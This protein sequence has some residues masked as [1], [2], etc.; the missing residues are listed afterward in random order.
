MILTAID[1]IVFN[2][3]RI[4]KEFILMSTII[5]IIFSK[6]FLIFLVI[7]FSLITLCYSMG[8]FDCFDEQPLNNKIIVVQHT[9]SH[10]YSNRKAIT[11]GQA[12]LVLFCHLNDIPFPEGY[13]PR[14]VDYIKVQPSHSG[15]H[16]GIIKNM[17]E[18]KGEDYLLVSSLWDYFYRID[19]IT[20]QVVFQGKTLYT[21][22]EC[23]DAFRS[24]IVPINNWKLEKDETSINYDFLVLRACIQTGYSIEQQKYH[25]RYGSL[26]LSKEMEK[27]SL[28]ITQEH[29][30][31]KTYQ[32]KMN[33]IKNN[34]NH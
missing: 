12:R 8:L 13:C 16:R 19:L 5:M 17:S 22:E 11:G 33:Q 9:V 26:K 32:R 3:K 30:Y 27:N 23:I 20:N 4:K 1:S 34:G 15:R 25:H 29:W 14:D 7:I 6:G 10:N 18:K 21:T 2:F 31:W 28:L 24:G